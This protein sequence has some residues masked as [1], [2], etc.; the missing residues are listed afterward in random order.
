M[1]RMA[2]LAS[3]DL[4]ERMFEPLVDNPFFVKDRSGAYVAANRA[5][6]DL[7]GLR[8]RRELI[9]RT[10]RDIYLPAD[11]ARFEV[12]DRIVLSGATIADRA[13]EVHAARRPPVWLIFSQHPLR[14]GTDGV[15]GIVGVARRM[16]LA[17]A[18]ER[19][20]ESFAAALRRLRARFDQPLDIAALARFAGLS[21]SQLERDFHR[22]LGATPRAYQQR[23]R[24]E[25]ALRLMPGPLSIS[26]IAQLA[27]FTDHSAFSRRFKAMTGLSPS[28]WRPGA[29]GLP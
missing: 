17:F 22:L 20:F 7:C 10:A 29:P 25:E 23:L 2:P 12:D 13:E 8:H 15:A 26:A 21:V 9:G 19:R 6:L 16:D 28:S 1:D 5:M 18:S 11:A 3:L 24:L 4:L 27:G 14:G